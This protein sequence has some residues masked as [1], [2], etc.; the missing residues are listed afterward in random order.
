MNTLE[1]NTEL[2]VHR[3]VPCRTRR[4][5]SGAKR[6]HRCACTSCFI[7][8][9]EDLLREAKRKATETGTTLTALI[10]ESL[11]ERL[12]RRVDR[13]RRETPVRLRTCA[14]TG[15]RPGI[16]LDDSASLLDTMDEQS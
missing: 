10:E 16:D 11:R 8:L 6:R 13:P 4:P 9:D 14:G 12:Q 5:D 7:R 15:L 1:D 2:S 3:L